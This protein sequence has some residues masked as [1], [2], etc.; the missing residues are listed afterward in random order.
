VHDPQ[1]AAAAA[2]RGAVSGLA[3][4]RDRLTPAVVSAIPSSDEA[5]VYQLE[6]ILK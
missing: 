6:L 3:F 5:A 1:L 4:A 2:L